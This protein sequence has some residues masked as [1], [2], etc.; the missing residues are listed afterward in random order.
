[1]L[2]NDILQC[3]RDGVKSREKYTETVRAFCFRL[4]GLSPKAYKFVRNEFGN[5]LPHTSTIKSWYRNS[6]LDTEPG[7]HESSLMI[8]ERKACEMKEN[9]QS[10]VCSLTFDEMSIRKHVQYCSKTKQ[11][12]GAVTYGSKKCEIANNAIVFLVN[13]IN[14]KVKVPV[15]YHFITS[16][17]GQDR[18]ALLLSVLAE[19]FKRG[20]TISNVT[21]DGLY[22]NQHMCTLLGANFDKNEMQTYFIEP[23]SQRKVYIIFDPSHMIKLL[24]NNLYNRKEFVD[25][26]GGKIEWK[27][28]KALVDF[29]E[30]NI[31]GL[32]HKLTN[33]HI[34]FK[35]KK[36]HVRTAVRTLSRSTADS[37]EFLMRQNIPVFENADSTIKFIRIVDKLFDVMN[38]QKVNHNNDNQF[39]SA[40]N[41]FNFDD[42]LEFLME[43]KEYIRGLKV[44]GQKSGKMLP[45]V[46]T[47]VKTGFCGFL[48]NVESVVNVYREYVE[49]KQLTYMIPTYQ[50]SQDHIEMLFC[51]IRELCRFTTTLLH[52]NLKEIINEFKCSV[53]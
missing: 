31:F 26:E 21:F 14:S 20:I 45:I 12:L 9:G 41:F 24:R 39:K 19:L 25:S 51:L 28:I 46:K 18:M 17:T 33:R 50:L 7:I 11:C 34:D 42:V 1:M 43:A 10:L 30:K 6:N 32:T 2:K 4:H 37:L 22:A 49:E 13:G 35:N 15:A 53:N 16:L 52:N 44:R 48:I 47:R 8:L 27:Y 3:L 40:I 23:Y 29:G 5:T 36:M 38:T